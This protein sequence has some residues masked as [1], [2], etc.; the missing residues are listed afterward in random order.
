MESLLNVLETRFTPDRITLHIELTPGPS[1]AFELPIEEAGK[2]LSMVAN[3]AATTFG[4]RAAQ[5]PPGVQGTAQASAADQAAAYIK[6]EVGEGNT[7][8]LSVIQG[9]LDRA[10]ASKNQK[11]IDEAR[12]R[13]EAVIAK[14]GRDSPAPVKS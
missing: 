10:R 8:A 9:E 11:A 5:P 4:V 1:V 3:Y 14:I 13:L 6:K 12:A 2:K 7:R